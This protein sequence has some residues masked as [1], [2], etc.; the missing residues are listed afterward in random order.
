[1]KRSYHHLLYLLGRIFFIGPGPKGMQLWTAVRTYRHDDIC[2]NGET[3]HDILERHFSNHP[4]L[5][6]VEQELGEIGKPL[7]EQLTAISE[8]TCCSIRLVTETRDLGDVPVLEEFSRANHGLQK[9][10]LCLY[11]VGSKMYILQEVEPLIVSSAFAGTLGFDIFNK[12]SD[13]MLQNLLRR[14]KDFA[15]CVCLDNQTRL[16]VSLPLPPWSI[17]FYK[18]SL[19]LDLMSIVLRRR[20]P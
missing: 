7:A 5:I 10:P 3:I 17:G 12:S 6:L 1:M 15:N 18:P 20:L 2:R 4:N 11:Q 14:Q 8:L 13:P 16:E 19:V 9:P